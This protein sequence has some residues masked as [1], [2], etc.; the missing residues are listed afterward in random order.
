MPS[1]QQEWP[2]IQLYDLTIETFDVVYEQAGAD[3]V[4]TLNFV[5]SDMDDFAG[6]ELD[7][8]SASAESEIH[9]T[10]TDN[11]LNIDPTAKDVV[12]FYVASGVEAVSFTDG[13]TY[14]TAIYKAYDNYF[15]DNGKLIINNNTSGTGVVLANDVTIDDATADNYM[16]FFEGA[17]NSGVFFNTDDDSDAS[18]VVADYAARGTAATFDYNDSA[19]SFVIANDFGTIDMDAS[20][21]GDEWNSGEEL[22]V[23]LIDQDLNK[24]T[25]SSED[26]L[27]VNTTNGHLVPS[28]QIGS[29]LTVL[30]TADDT[31]TVSHLVKLHITPTPLLVAIRNGW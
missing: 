15:D 26:L 7:R 13:A 2:L 24:N 8:N 5:S 25:A 12:I 10:I 27:L 31:D 20:S 16:V 11:Q 9:L 30:T 4:V 17:E 1:D 3:E 23:T 21:V 22:S 28:L 19:Q 18:L 6:M 14:T 29:P